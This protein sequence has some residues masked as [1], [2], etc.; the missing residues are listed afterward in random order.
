M[1]LKNILLGTSLVDMYAKCGVLH[2]AKV[3]EEL[4][5]WDFASWCALIAG[6]AKKDKG[7][8]AL[9]Y[10]QQMQQEGISP[11]AVPYTCILKACGIMQDV[12]MG[13]RIQNDIFN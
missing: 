11:N 4:S 9:G 6:F 3:L 13:I 5:V 1:L 8:E 2:K 10:F 7:Q 12:E